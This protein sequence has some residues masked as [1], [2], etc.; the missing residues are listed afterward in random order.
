MPLSISVQTRVQGTR[1]SLTRLV[2]G[3]ARVAR[4]RV[5]FD[6]L[7]AAEWEGIRRN[8]RVGGLSITIPVRISNLRLAG[9]AINQRLNSVATDMAINEI[10]SEMATIVNDKGQTI[11]ESVWD[12]SGIEPNFTRRPTAIVTSVEILQ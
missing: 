3:E 10:L 2:R 6:L 8:G 12:S 11:D 9:N 4:V 1:N 7:W 5:N